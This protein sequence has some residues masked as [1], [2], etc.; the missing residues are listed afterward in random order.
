MLDSVR[1]ELWL[2]F[3]ARATPFRDM[4]VCVRARVCVCV[5][6]RRMRVCTLIISANRRP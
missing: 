6:M 5:C 3:G 2:K 4:C 1:L